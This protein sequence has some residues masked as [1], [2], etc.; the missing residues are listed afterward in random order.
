MPL[1]QIFPIQN[2]LGNRRVISH[3]IGERALKTQLLTI[4]KSQF[5]MP[6]KLAKTY[7]VRLFFPGGSKDK[8]S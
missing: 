6:L 4:L 7:R 1:S 2:N 3:L 5:Y 8:D